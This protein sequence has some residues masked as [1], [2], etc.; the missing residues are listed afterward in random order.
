MVINK[1]LIF[2]YHLLVGLHSPGDIVDFRNR[3]NILEEAEN[4]KLKR[5]LNYKPLQA[6][7][8]YRQILLFI[9]FSCYFKYEHF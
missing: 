8:N 4:Q 5:L 3:L 7:S 1:N 6:K 2:T 9:K